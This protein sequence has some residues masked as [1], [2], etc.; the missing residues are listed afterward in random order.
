MK[1][2]LPSLRVCA[3]RSLIVALATMSLDSCVVRPRRP[4]PPAAVVET[5]GGE[6]TVLP[7]GGRWTTYRGERVWVRRGVY[8]RRGVR[9]YVVFHP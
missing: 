6:V 3:Q 5:D 2:S 4:P 9:G 7:R 8:Y 1:M